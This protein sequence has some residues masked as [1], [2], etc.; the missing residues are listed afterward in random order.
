MTFYRF[1]F[2]SSFS[3]ADCR[4]IALRIVKL[5]RF[6]T[7]DRCHFRDVESEAM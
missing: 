4:D 1:L 7:L 6:V 5:R 2:A 3:V